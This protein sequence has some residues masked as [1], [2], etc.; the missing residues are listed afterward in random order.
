MGKKKE[1]GAGLRELKR[2]IRELERELR[3]G[4]RQAVAERE[5]AEAEK[6]QLLAEEER[7]RQALLNVLD[8]EQRA[9]A[10]LRSSEDR[11]HDFVEHTR[12]LLCTHDLQGNILWAN[13]AARVA[14]GYSESELQ[15]MSL[16]DVLAP[17]VRVSL[18]AYLD[19][20]RARG[21][22]SGHMLVCTKGGEQRLWEYQNS[23]RASD[24]P[25]PI[26]RGMARDVTE[27]LRT[28]ISLRDS[29]SRLRLAVSASHIGLWDWDVRTN[30]VHYSPE[31]KNQLGYREDEIAA[32]Y[33][34]WASRLH[35]E[36][37]PLALARLEAHLEGRTPAYEVEFR[38]R[39]KNGSWRWVAARGEAERD[40]AGRITC[41]RGCHIDITGRKHVEDELRAQGQRLQ[42]LSRR[43]VEVEESERGKIHQELHDRIG[44]NLS[45]LSVTL[46]LF[47]NILAK[48]AHAAIQVRLEDAQ[49][50]VE[51]TTA[52]LRDIMAE[53][54]PPALDDYGLVGAL[55]AHAAVVGGRTA[56]A[57][58]VRAD[59]A[60]PRLAIGTET[61]LFRIA[62]E[63]LNNVVKHARARNA[64]I[65]VEVNLRRLR[66]TVSDDGAG[67]DPAQRDPL[68]GGWGLRIMRER[69]EAIGAHLAIHSSPG[70]G[71]RVIA[72]VPQDAA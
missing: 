64:D 36:D 30:S 32:R 35:P 41:V 13:R 19:E 1:A 10:A 27:S 72:E 23:L 54:R 40:A 70:R 28:E 12:E 45:A 47:R 61:A 53:L 14:L 62:Q 39:H 69:A 42:V 5:A 26:V 43:L 38:M 68:A 51:E 50:L 8:D 49:K 71:T 56:L 67:F 25:V 11:Y 9:K 31:W 16:R 37:K 66:I 6:D 44:P 33:E 17:S 20:I 57:V 59:A 29:E 22:A 4:R 18:Q 3:C 21:I 58:R 15:A 7:V 55:R 2:R 46:S 60:E 63:A 24:V 34:E 48:D 52:Q 65:R